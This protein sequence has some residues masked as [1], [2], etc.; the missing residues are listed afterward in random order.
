M[1]WLLPRSTNSQE[2]ILSSVDL[3]FHVWKQI[4]KS[5]VVSYSIRLAPI[6]SVH[7]LFLITSVFCNKRIKS[8]LTRFLNYTNPVFTRYNCYLENYNEYV[9]VICMVKQNTS[10]LLNNRQWLNMWT[11]THEERNDGTHKSSKRSLP[12]TGRTR[13]ALKIIRRN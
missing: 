2:H 8:S 11:W 13:K 4:F 7:M 12:W 6:K 9:N 1:Q 5:R 10:H 3:Q